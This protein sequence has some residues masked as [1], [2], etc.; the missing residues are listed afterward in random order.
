MQLTGVVDRVV[1]GAAKAVVRAWARGWEIG[2][3]AELGTPLQGGPKRR[4][5]VVLLNGIACD[6]E[7]WRAF[8]RSL[9]RD[10]FDVTI[11]ELPNKALDDIGASADYVRDLIAKVRRETGAKR[12]DLVGYSE[13]GLIGREYIRR[14]GKGAA[15]DSLV[16][17]GTPHNGWGPKPLGA[18]TRGSK[19]LTAALPIAL[20]QMIEGSAFLAQLNSGDPTPGDVRYTS[21]MSQ[22]WD[23]I[24]WPGTSPI[25]EGAKNIVLGQEGRVPLF[26][27]PNHGQLIQRSNVAYET[28]R[29][30]LLAA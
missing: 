8:A 11:A 28:V 23:G 4:D 3:P 21:I 10:G 15:V 22:Q 27:G 13:G 6:N 5:P 1:D 7:M 12:V 19:L 9:R 29:G 17:L 26:A 2:G 20:Q 24:V 14:A 30:A 18:I 25:L 16:T